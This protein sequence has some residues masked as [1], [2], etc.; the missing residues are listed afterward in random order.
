M[1]HTKPYSD[2][3]IDLSARIML[4]RE[5]Q[6]VV[7]EKI[8]RQTFRPA[9]LAAALASIVILSTGCT[10]ISLESGSFKARRT[11]WFNEVEGNVLLTTPDGAKLEAKSLKS[12]VDTE[13]LNTLISAAAG[14]V[15]P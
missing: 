11:A 13:A 2:S 12:S 3:A 15:K 7:R 9:H 6:R 14:A 4:V 10:T 5:R 8:Q 1:N